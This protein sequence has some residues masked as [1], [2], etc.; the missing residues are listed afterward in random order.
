[1]TK[2]VKGHFFKKNAL[3]EQKLLINNPNDI[4]DILKNI[5]EFIWGQKG[6]KDQIF[7]ML[8]LSWNLYG[9]ILMTL[10]AS[11]YNFENSSE[12]I[13]LSQRCQSFFELEF[14]T[15]GQTTLWWNRS[16]YDPMLQLGDCL[17]KLWQP[18][19]LHPPP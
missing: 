4:L 6:V 5:L 8:Q 10:Q 1:M 13:R 19:F 7:D 15:N 2:V 18:M 3:I 17:I 11:E 9:M 16:C 12:I 14:M